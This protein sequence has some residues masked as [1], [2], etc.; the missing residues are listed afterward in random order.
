MAIQIGKYKRPGIFLEEFDKSVIATPIVEGITN[1]VI[2]VS[3]KGPINTP[4]RLT[5]VNDLEAIFGSLDRGLERKGS[6]FHRTVS[7]MLE[8]APV[9]AMNLL[10]TDDTLD[11]I[12]YKSLS[13]SADYINDIEREGPYRRF[14]D[15]TGF[16]KRDTESFIN[17]TKGNTGYEERA[18]SLTNLSDRYTTVFMFKTARTGFDRTLIEWYGSAEKVPPYVNVNDYASDYMV[19]IVIVAGDWS[20]YSELAVDSRWSAYFNTSGLRKEQV[21]N[22]SNDRN[23]TTLAYYEGISLI[24]YFRDGNGT[25]VFIETIVNRDTDKTGIFCAFNND[26]VEAD[27][28]NGMLDL[29]GHTIAGKNETNIEFLSYKETIAEEVEISGTPLDLPGNVTA[30]MGLS[31]SLIGKDHA[32]GTTDP[33]NAGIVENGNR[34]AY[35]AEGY[36]HNIMADTLVYD[37]GTLYIPYL[38]TGD[39]YA[40][41]GGEYLALTGATLSISAGDYASASIATYSSAFV[42]DSTGTFKVVSSSSANKPSVATSDIV[43]GYAELVL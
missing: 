1:M 23:V 35:F 2:G 17:L 26:L 36:V 29:I 4:V 5:T 20:N 16:W 27:Y 31:Y 9:Y 24:P 28:F 42:L 18:F 25:N 30:L 22:F 3:K 43:L 14:H 13:G 10:L 33:S 19:D 6:F 21:R 40:I 34:T 39:A 38:T 11:V 7:K 12:E 37:N 8:S 15:T 32:F 41:I